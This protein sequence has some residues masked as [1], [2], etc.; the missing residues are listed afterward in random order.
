MSNPG[1]KVPEDRLVPASKTDPARF[2][3]EKSGCPLRRVRHEDT[4][5]GFIQCNVCH[6]RVWPLVRN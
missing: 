2:A 4:L 3:C 5:R 1:G 6:R